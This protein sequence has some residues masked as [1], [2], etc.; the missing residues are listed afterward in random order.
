[1]RMKM[2]PETMY[3]KLCVTLADFENA[4]DDDTDSEWMSDGEW[5]DVFYELCVELQN[6][7]G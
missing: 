5:L 3:D 1:M 2:L 4:T 7:V 6:S